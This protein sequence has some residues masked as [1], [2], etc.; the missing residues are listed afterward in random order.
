VNKDC[1]T[2]A[3]N[4]LQRGARYAPRPGGDA[5]ATAPGGDAQGPALSTAAAPADGAVPTVYD[6][7]TGV[8][9]IPGGGT[10]RI[11]TGIHG[12]WMGL[13]LALLSS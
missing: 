11:G 8:I 1:T 6:P 9:A 12:S 13:L 7:Q 4:M 3:P 2:I 5:T 10:V